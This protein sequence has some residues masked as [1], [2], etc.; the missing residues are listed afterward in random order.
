M[1]I[2][3][4]AA[5]GGQILTDERIFALADLHAEDSA[6]DGSRTFDR[7]GLIQFATDLRAPPAAVPASEPVAKQFRERMNDGTWGGWHPYPD[8]DVL[9]GLIA[10]DHE[11]RELYTAAPVSGMPDLAAMRAV[12]QQFVDYHTKPAG[13]TLGIATNRECFGVF[14]E[15]IEVREKAMVTRAS[16]LL[17][18][19]GETK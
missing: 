13:M 10:P 4:T 2:Q 9:I 3:N 19:T 14:L 1:A 8:E 15:D 17:N 12:L 18:P 5:N 6:E 7:G 11:V 16:A